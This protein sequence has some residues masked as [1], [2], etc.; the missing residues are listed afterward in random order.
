[1]KKIVLAFGR[2]NPVTSGHQKLVSKLQ[3]VA[4]LQKADSAL[5]LSHTQD[6]KKNPL[7]YNDKIKYATKAFGGIVK[8]SPAKTIIQILKELDSQYDDIVYVAGSDRVEEFK[9]ML[10]KYNGKGYNFNSIEIVSA[11]ERDPGAD[12]VSGMSA[13]KLRELAASGEFGAFKG[14]LP[15]KLKNSKE[16]KEMYEKIRNAMGITEDMTLT[17]VLNMQQRLKRKAMM[18][19]IK[20][21]IKLGRKRAAKRMANNDKLKTRS[22]RKAREQIRARLAGARGKNYKDLPYGAR[23][24]IDKRVSKKS[25]AIARLAKKL[26]PKVRKAEQERLKKARTQKEDFEILNIVTE[27]LDN[28]ERTFVSEKVIHNLQKKS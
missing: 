21:K 27:A 24:E 12:D 8:N 16:A 10:N 18:R 1:M 17:E 13:S 9:T 20:S 26:L 14:G 15:T 23:A 5:Y 4:K 6:K 7:S 3:S 19:R 28:I 25:T 2:M 11:G 22:N